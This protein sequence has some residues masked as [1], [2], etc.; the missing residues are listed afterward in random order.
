M[1]A[2]WTPGGTLF[3]GTHHL[4]RRPTTP[5]QAKAISPPPPQDCTELSFSYPDWTV[6]DLTYVQPVSWDNAAA[7]AS[8]NTSISHRPTGVRWRC[9]WGAEAGV[10]ERWAFV[11]EYY[12]LPVCKIEGVDPLNSNSSLLVRFNANTKSITVDQSWRC[13]DTAGTYSCV[14]HR[15]RRRGHKG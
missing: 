2:Q 12:M 14:D 4:E 3:P 11:S 8:F 6:H 13:G 5:P 10:T 1:K 7:T 9:Q 15:G